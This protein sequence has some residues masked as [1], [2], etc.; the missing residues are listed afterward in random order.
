MHSLVLISKFVNR[1]QIKPFLVNSVKP[2]PFLFIL[3]VFM[4][5]YGLGFFFLVKITK[6]ELSSSDRCLDKVRE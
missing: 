2:P 4:L 3:S 1:L 5:L 6:F